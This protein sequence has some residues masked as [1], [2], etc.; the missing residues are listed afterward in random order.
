MQYVQKKEGCL[1]FLKM[2]T[3]LPNHSV[4]N[5]TSLI[6]SIIQGSNWKQPVWTHI[7]EFTPK[8]S[9]MSKGKTVVLYLFSSVYAIVINLSGFIPLI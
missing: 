2:R 1:T 8:F 3:K 7:E 9:S 6:I 5:F 4:L